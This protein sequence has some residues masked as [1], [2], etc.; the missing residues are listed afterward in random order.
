MSQPK[1]SSVEEVKAPIL[2]HIEA[3]EAEEL[4]PGEKIDDARG[5]AISGYESLSIF[6]TVKTF[7]M[8]TL[9]CF[10]AAFS[11]ATDGYQIGMNGSIVANKGFVKQF[12]TEVNAKGELYLASPVLVGW[13]SI[14]SVGQIIGMTTLPFLAGRYGRKVS[15][16]TY[17]VII[18]ASVIAE[19]LARSWPH[20]LVAK[21]LAGVGVGCLQ[22]TI[23]SY[24]SEVAPNRIRGSLLMCYSLW[25][26]AGSFF[27]YIALQT[28]ARKDPYNWL[29]PVLTQWAQVGLM[30]IIYIFLPESPAWCGTKGDTERGKKALRRTHSGVDGYDVDYQYQI[31][32]LAVEHEKAIAAEQHRESWTAIFKGVNGFRTVVSLW[33]NMST[34]FVGLTLFGTFGTY[35]FQQAGLDDPFM[36]KCIVSGINIGTIF[37][38]IYSAD[39]IGRRLIACCATTLA[40]LSCVA[41]GILGVSPQVKATNY[42]FV[43]FA[44]LWNI[45]MTGNG[46]AGWGF[47]GEISSQRLR[48]YTAGFGAASTCVVGVMMSTL[49]PY[50]VNANQ[51]AW[52][53]KAGWFYA[54]V[55][56]PFTVGMWLL[57]PETRG[58]SA[59]ELDELFERRI[60][61]WRFHETQ[62][63]T[64]RL[65]ELEQHK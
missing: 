29:R 22:F 45:G 37:V 43:L 33:T 50:M 57:I 55:G 5:Q 38:I 17:W 60:K 39:L 25:W 47:I 4:Q 35:F 64:Q 63:A 53:F 18:T 26:T 54:G 30:L 27:A 40:W 15:M 19:S 23:P 58:R 61:P 8:A 65:V 7:K 2:D 62:T 52:G 14:M 41:I 28:M 36:I 9:I 12:A 11:A 59:A 21:L 31:L 13:S 6:E 1:P 48:P 16:Y 20:W 42:I 46:A 44:V 49:V 32:C 24:I 51:W 56:L 10:L 3:R 34:Q